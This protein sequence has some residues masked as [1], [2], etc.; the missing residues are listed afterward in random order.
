MFKNLIKPSN[1]KFWILVSIIF[2]FI[3]F[4]ISLDYNNLDYDKPYLKVGDSFD[5]IASSN[6]FILNDEFTFF[7]TTEWGEKSNLINQKD[8]DK[9]LFYSYRSPGYA[10]I[11]V[12]LYIVIY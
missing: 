9:S 11:L 10:F 12:P 8:F 4:K 1:W 2:S 3:Q 5:Y 7:K 6:A